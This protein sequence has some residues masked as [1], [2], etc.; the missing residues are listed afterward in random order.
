MANLLESRCWGYH[1]DLARLL[2]L[3]SPSGLGQQFGGCHLAEPDRL[4]LI[5]EDIGG[6]WRAKGLDL[7][8]E[9]PI[10]DGLHDLQGRGVVSR[11]DRTRLRIVGKVAKWHGPVAGPA[12]G[13]GTHEIGCLHTVQNLGGAVLDLG[14]GV[15]GEGEAHTDVISRIRNIGTHVGKR[16]E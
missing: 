7:E 5:D 9:L 2:A 16:S 8:P 6:G 15:D 3:E 11:S 13:Y 12:A 1:D 14:C 4:D 10:A